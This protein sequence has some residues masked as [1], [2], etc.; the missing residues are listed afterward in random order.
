M[1]IAAA[2]DGARLVATGRNYSEVRSEV[3]A[4]LST[5]LD[6][7]AATLDYLNEQIFG[8]PKI[9]LDY[10]AAFQE[11]LNYQATLHGSST[12]HGL[13][14]IDQYILFNEAISATFKEAA[15]RIGRDHEGSI[16]ATF[17]EIDQA[18]TIVSRFMSEHHRDIETE[19]CSPA[20]ARDHGVITAVLEE[21]K[22]ASHGKWQAE[23]VTVSNRLTGRDRPAETPS[24]ERFSRIARNVRES[25]LK[26]G[27]FR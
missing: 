22:Q 6:R 25:R 2:H 18:A 5:Q 17:A 13:A 12:H 19:R 9:Y 16:S 24:S 21:L 4:I 10:L 8:A 23:F 14:Y 20:Y 27:L 7:T 11:R 15:D 1:L 26:L 3:F